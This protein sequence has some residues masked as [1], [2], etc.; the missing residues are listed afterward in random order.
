M[1]VVMAWYTPTQKAE[2]AWNAKEAPAQSDE[3]LRRTDSQRQPTII[4][5]T[6]EDALVSAPEPQE[7]PWWAW[8]EERLD[9]ERA[10]MCDALAEF[11]VGWVGPKLDPI[12]RENKLLRDELALL[13]SQHG[14]LE[15]RIVSERNAAEQARWV[16][17]AENAVLRREFDQL[18]SEVGMERGIRDLHKDVAEARQ[19]IPSVPAI[20]ERLNAENRSLKTKLACLEQELG[21]MKKKLGRVQVDQSVAGYNC[22]TADY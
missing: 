12:K 22:V 17:A 10:Q 21:R 1:E 2:A 18:R 7:Q 5:K 8:V 6:N 11:V 20:E 13:R 19:Q 4:H 9:A 15:E 14:V 3:P 16:L